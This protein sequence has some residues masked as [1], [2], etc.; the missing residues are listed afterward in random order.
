MSRL[1]IV[2]GDSGAGTLKQVLAGS[3]STDRV[4]SLG[5]DLSWGPIGRDKLRERIAY[6]DA[7]CPIPDGWS[8]LAEAHEK[9]GEEVA[10]EWDERLVWL[11]S[12]SAAELAGYLFYLD[13]FGELPA[14]VIRPDEHL[15]PHPRFGPA[16]SIGVLNASDVAAVLE[17]APR[18]PVA[19]DI[20]LYGRWAELVA[21]GALLRVL[22]DG[23]LRSAP[24]D[25][26]D[27]LILSAVGPE[28]KLGIRVIGDAI[29]ASF[30]ERVQ[31]NSDFLFMR[32]SELAKHGV[33]EAEGD[34]LG[35]TEDM[36][37]LPV[38][39]RKG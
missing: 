24:L 18:R 2:F 4:V 15:P 3:R 31:I 22:Q 9:F 19:D 35:W 37:R 16:G 1:H 17:K 36:R 7:F 27:H 25:H 6:F 21:D 28:W 5:D 32:L 26:F 11:G 23:G 10:A 39:V 29:G 34:V 13:R 14:Q 30:D 38:N 8:W 20:A 12:A 33:L